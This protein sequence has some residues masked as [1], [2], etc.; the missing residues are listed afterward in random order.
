MY[1]GRKVFEREERRDD[2]PTRTHELMQ[3]LA[4]YYVNEKVY[5]NPKEVCALVEMSNGE[6]FFMKE[7]KDRLTDEQI[8]QF[9][10]DVWIFVEKKDEFVSPIVNGVLA[11]FLE[12]QPM[13]HFICRLYESDY[14][15]AYDRI[16]VALEDDGMH[17]YL[18]M[19]DLYH[20]GD[21]SYALI[22]EYMNAL[23]GLTDEQMLLILPSL[24]ENFPQEKESILD[25]VM[26]H[27]YWTEDISECMRSHVR[28]LLLYCQWV[29]ENGF[30]IRDRRVIFTEV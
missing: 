12:K 4:E 26:K 30:G 18:K 11:T 10:D 1:T 27:R 25:F 7:L 2:V 28:D 16:L 20:K 19:L 9:I 21:I 6:G 14:K 5:A 15:N 24:K 3:P 13:S 29:A 8:Q 23:W 22:S 17:S